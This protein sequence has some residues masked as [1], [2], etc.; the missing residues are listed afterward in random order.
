MGEEP[1]L[2]DLSH[3]T[4]E[5]GESVMWLLKDGGRMWLGGFEGSCF[6]HRHLGF[7]CCCLFRPLQVVWACDLA[8]HPGES[9]LRGV[10][11]LLNDF[12]HDVHSLSGSEQVGV[13]GIGG[14]FSLDSGCCLQR[15]LPL[16]CCFFVCLL[17]L[18]LV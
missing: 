14:A 5:A 7:F 2:I 8:G 12:L 6:G 16:S 18:I 1:I 3:F 10:V 13:G 9:Q 15:Q 11:V 4:Q 17:Q